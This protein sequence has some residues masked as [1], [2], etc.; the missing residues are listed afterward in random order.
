MSLD[1]Q[2]GIPDLPR[3]RNN[4][5]DFTFYPGGM[6]LSSSPRPGGGTVV[7]RRERGKELI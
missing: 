4:I 3:R 2:Y 7:G 6:K 5:S 1:D